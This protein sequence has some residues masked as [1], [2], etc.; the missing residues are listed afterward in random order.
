[1]HLETILNH[2]YKIKDFVKER[3]FFDKIHLF[4]I[5]KFV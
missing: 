4:S 2:G 5:I 1:M 3:I